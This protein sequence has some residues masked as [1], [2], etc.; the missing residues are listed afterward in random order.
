M[1]IREISI[2][3]FRCIRDATVYLD[4]LTVFLG[5]NGSGKSTILKSC[6]YFFDI[7]A[8]ITEDDFYNLDTTLTIEI[9]VVFSDLNDQEN[10]EFSGFVQDGCFSVTKL[11]KFENDSVDQKYYGAFQQ[12]PLLAEVR[13]LRTLTDKRNRWNELVDAGALPEIGPLSVRGDNL[14]ELM[15]DYEINHPDLCQWGRKEVQFLGPKNIGGGSLDNYSK[16]VLVPAVRDVM[17][18]LSDKRGSPLYQLLDMLVIRRIKSRDDVLQLQVDFEERFKDV[19]SPENMTEFS[20]LAE[21]ISRTLQ[22]FV[23]NARLGLNPTEPSLPNLPIPSPIPTLIEDDFEGSIDRKGHGLQRALLFSLLQHLAVTSLNDEDVENVEDQAEIVPGENEE[24]QNEIVGPCLILA[25]E[26]PELYQHPLRAK[27]L[28]NVLLKM[29]REVENVHGGGMQV[30]YT[31]HSPYFV[32]L[33]RFSNL[34]IIRKSLLVQN[35]APC[36]SISQ[37]TLESASSEMARITQ[38]PAEE[39]TGDSFRAHAYPVMTHLVNEGFFANAVVITE[40]LTEVAA[41]TAVSNLLNRDW[42]SK[43]IAVI[44]AEGKNKIDRS[45]VIFSGFCIPN[46]FVFDGDNKYDTETSSNRN[47]TIKENAILLRLAN[48]DV[49]EFPDTTISNRYTCF[50]DDFES[51]CLSEIGDLFYEL[52]DKIAIEYGYNQPSNGIKNFEVVTDLI[53]EIYSRG[54]NLPVI[55]SIIENVESLL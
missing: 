39:F 12:I 16:F 28:S 43:G 26:E 10:A 9:R 3:N 24:P 20:S 44:S 49:V 51:Y 52:R 35:E 45:V 23:P 40:G 47:Q 19:Y 17:D 30:I 4:N 54:L 15:T 2:K 11:I 25:I 5:Q 14:E 21:D 37:Y 42:L 6:D 36:S 50:E 27:H 8:P 13:R 41:I 53:A 31:T 22:T 48:A 34:R 7:K 18:D 29:S 33:S 46:Y 55:E 32:D 38:R 1:L